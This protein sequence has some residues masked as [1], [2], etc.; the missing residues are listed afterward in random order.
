MPDIAD[1][2]FLFFIYFFFKSVFIGHEEN[3]SEIVIIAQEELDD[4]DIGENRNA[5]TYLG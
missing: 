4:I 1:T 5:P 3:G 2:D